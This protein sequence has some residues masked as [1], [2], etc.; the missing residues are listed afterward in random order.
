[1]NLKKYKC[2]LFDHRFKYNF[3][4]LPNKRI[5]VN[6]YKKEGL[7]LKT[8]EWSETFNDERTDDELIN[9]WVW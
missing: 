1:M 5:C 3:P 2:I 4:S 9:K 6:C 8:L 7:N